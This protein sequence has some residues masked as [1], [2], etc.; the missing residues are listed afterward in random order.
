MSKPTIKAVSLNLALY[1]RVSTERQDVEGV[2]IEQQIE[3]IKLWAAR[4]HHTV[5]DVFLERGA[6]AFSV[7]KRRP[8]FDRMVAKALL[9]ER[10]YDLIVV[11]SQSRLYR[12]NAERELLEQKLERNGVRVAISSQ[13][14]P[15]DDLTSFL[16][17]NIQGSVDEWQSRNS[18]K[19][20]RRMH[21][22]KC[23]RRLLQWREATIR[24]RCRA[25]RHSGTE[26]RKKNLESQPRRGGSG[27]PHL[28]SCPLR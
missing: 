24:I 16:V 21:A 23:E 7:E 15:E 13:P 5:V 2:S 3:Q 6:S 27:S 14:R 22:K 1:G 20:R 12:N 8:Q 9:P 26:R 19:T 18:G 10:P 25:N 17:R 4:N 28:S 11:H